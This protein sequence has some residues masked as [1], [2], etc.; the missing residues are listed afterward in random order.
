[1]STYG[2]DLQMDERRVCTLPAV[3]QGKDVGSPV[4]CRPAGLGALR[5]CGGD[6]AR[7]SQDRAA[8]VMSAKTIIT[9]HYFR[10]YRRMS[11]V[12]VPCYGSTVPLRTVFLQCTYFLVIVCSPSIPSRRVWP[13]ACS[14][15]GGDMSGRRANMRISSSSLCLLYRLT[16]NKSTRRM[17][18]FV[19]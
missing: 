11:D 15:T 12:C 19:A 13:L 18:G 8:A 17:F 9:R 3:S 5:R 10:N 7:N 16:R 6:H 4:V 2:V 14:V 1:M